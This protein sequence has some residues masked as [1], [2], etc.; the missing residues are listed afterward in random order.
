MRVSA[1]CAAVTWGR[2]GFARLTRARHD[3]GAPLRRPGFVRDSVRSFC[4]LC[5]LYLSGTAGLHGWVA[6]LR[7]G[8]T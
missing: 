6:R 7:V 3:M 4:K 1:E 5:S 2:S 8:S